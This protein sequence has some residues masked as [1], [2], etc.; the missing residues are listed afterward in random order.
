MDRPCSERDTARRCRLATSACS[1][2]RRHRARPGPRRH[3]CA[4]ER[5]RHKRSSTSSMPARY[6]LCS[7]PGTLRCH[8]RALLCLQG[9]LCLHGAGTPQRGSAPASHHHKKWC[10]PPTWPTRQP[11]SPL[12]KECCRTR[13][14][15]RCAGTPCHRAW[16]AS[17]HARASALHCHMFWC[18]RSMM[19][20]PRGRNPW[21]KRRCCTRGS[22]CC[23]DT[24]CHR[25]A[26]TPNC[27]RA[28]ACRRRML[29]STASIAPSSARH[30]RSDSGVCRKSATALTHQE[31]QLPQP[32]PAPH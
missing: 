25:A 8:R 22:R 2:T 27:A 19:P 21:D 32:R 28:P 16:P 3:A 14:S 17:H 6:R 5:R 30:S 24:P 18:T 23:A 10:T 11:C 26:E 12:G 7:P 15:P 20:S 29:P 1:G 9:T 13:A 31:S 4:A